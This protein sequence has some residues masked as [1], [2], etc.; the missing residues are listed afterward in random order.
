LKCVKSAI[1]TAAM[2]ETATPKNNADTV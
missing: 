2:V 1:D